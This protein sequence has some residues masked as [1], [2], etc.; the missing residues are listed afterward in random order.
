MWLSFFCVM[1]LVRGG[2]F[3]SS[4]NRGRFSCLLVWMLL[5]EVLMCRVWSWWWIMMFFSIWEFMCIGLGGWFVLGK[6]D[7][8]LCCCW[9]CRRGGFFRC[10]LKLGYL[11]CGGMSFLVSCCSFWFFGMRRFCFSWRSLLRKSISR[12]WFRLGFGGF[13]GLY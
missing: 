3:W 5:F 10:W 2:G 13:E 12:G 11:S 4:L 6:L 1:V 9:K 7:R 8:F